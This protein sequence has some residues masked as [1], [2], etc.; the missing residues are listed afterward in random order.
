MHISRA[1][2]LFI[3]LFLFAYWW[4]DMLAMSSQFVTFLF[5]SW[6]RAVYN[7]NNCVGDLYFDFTVYWCFLNSVNEI[8]ISEFRVFIY[9]MHTQRCIIQLCAFVVPV[10]FFFYRNIWFC[11]HKHHK[12]TKY[13]C[14]VIFGDISQ[15]R[16][17]KADVKKRTGHI[18]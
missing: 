17:L 13:I 15:I 12:F 4:G 14:L 2:I 1:R 8:L 11:F 18:W 5:F 16:S 6:V 10:F 7:K 9:Y 3:S